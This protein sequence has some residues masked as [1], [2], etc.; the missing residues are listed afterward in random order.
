MCYSHRHSQPIPISVTYWIRSL[1][2]RYP[3]QQTSSMEGFVSA[4]YYHHHSQPHT[5][6]NTTQSTLPQIPGVFA[7]AVIVIGEMV[8]EPK[9]SP[10]RVSAR[11]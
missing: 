3:L 8:D 9:P 11:R 10:R 2:L 4:C 5:D 6:D 7:S 1:I